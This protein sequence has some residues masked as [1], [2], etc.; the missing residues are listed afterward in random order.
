MSELNPIPT[1]I[2]H[3][4][5]K[6]LMV[7]A[8][9]EACITDPQVNDLQED[10]EIFNHLITTWSE[11][12]KEILSNLEKKKEHITKGKSANSLMALGAMEVHLNMAMQALKA[13]EK[14][15]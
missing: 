3:K 1:S 2:S 15:E 6:A 13:S 14:G 5:L 10:Q 8:Y 11:L 4:K 9:K 12:S 7:K